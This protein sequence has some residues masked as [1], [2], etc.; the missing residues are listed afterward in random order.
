M[1]SGLECDVVGLGGKMHA[2]QKQ[3]EHLRDFG[4]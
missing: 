2:V 4:V 1:S 3:Q